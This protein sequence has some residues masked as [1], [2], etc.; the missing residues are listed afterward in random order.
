LSFPYISLS[1]KYPLGFCMEKLTSLSMGELSLL[2]LL[3][4]GFQ[5]F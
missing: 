5:H 4:Y 2:F 1:N 3:Y